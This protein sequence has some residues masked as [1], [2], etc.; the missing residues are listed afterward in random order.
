MRVSSLIFALLLI[1]CNESAGRRENGK[2]DY[3]TWEVIQFNGHTYVRWAMSGH[4]NMIHDP[5]CRCN[6][7]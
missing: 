5:D 3:G 7:K 6:K 4:G 2:P 1:G